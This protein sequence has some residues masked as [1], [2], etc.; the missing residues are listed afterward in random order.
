M[1]EDHVRKV[2]EELE[3]NA[4]VDQLEKDKK[5][6]MMAAFDYNIYGHKVFNRNNS[7]NSTRRGL[8]K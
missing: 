6:Q 8:T 1:K 5:F 4:W 7:L 2:L 3:F